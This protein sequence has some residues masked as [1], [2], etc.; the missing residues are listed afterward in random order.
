MAKKTGNRPE[1]RIYPGT[2]QLKLY[3]GEKGESF[4]EDIVD[5]FLRDKVSDEAAHAG[6]LFASFIDY[7]R[8]NASDKVVLSDGRMIPLVSN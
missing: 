4:I 7:C 8:D 1:L 3:T 2:P 5:S 6:E